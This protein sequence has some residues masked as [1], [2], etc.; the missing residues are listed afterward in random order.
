MHVYSNSSVHD[1]KKKKTIFNILHPA[2][3]L[4]QGC[5]R[6]EG[7]S[8]AQSMDLQRILRNPEIVLRKTLDPWFVC[9]I[10]RL[11]LYTLKKFQ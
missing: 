8:Y 9:A 2:S 11:P 5:S 4:Y 3:S 1:F 7:V 6:R 10:S